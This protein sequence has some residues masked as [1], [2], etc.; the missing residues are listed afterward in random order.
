MV[1]LLQIYF[2]F[3]RI[4]DKE[5]ITIIKDIWDDTRPKIFE[6]VKN[7]K[8]SALRVL[9]EESTSCVSEG[10]NGAGT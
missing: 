7:E 9:H 5:M 2:E 10:I 6:V 3:N 4:F 1:I 8:G